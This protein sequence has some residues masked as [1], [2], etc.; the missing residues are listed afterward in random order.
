MFYVLSVGRTCQAAEIPFLILFLSF[1]EICASEVE[2]N[3]KLGDSLNISS[4]NYPYQYPTLQ[5]YRLIEANAGA[6]QIKILDSRI[7][8]LDTIAIGLGL[9]PSFPAA[10]YAINAAAKSPS[11]DNH[12]RGIYVP[13]TIIGSHMWIVIGVGHTYS[14]PSFHQF[15]TITMGFLMEISV[16]AEPGNFKI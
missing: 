10:V 9:N 13:S 6:F 3:L 15:D 16:L 8:V 2:I 5:C 14:R 11:L 7:S 12:P 4:N 1:T